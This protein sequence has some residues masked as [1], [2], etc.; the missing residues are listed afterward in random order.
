MTTFVC[1]VIVMKIVMTIRIVTIIIQLIT[2]IK[3]IMIY[4]TCSDD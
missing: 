2:I 4:K 1:M 3:Y